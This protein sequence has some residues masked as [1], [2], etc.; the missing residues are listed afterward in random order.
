MASSHSYGEILDAK[1][2]PHFEVQCVKVKSLF[3][4]GYL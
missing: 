2:N 3:L 4:K 1:S